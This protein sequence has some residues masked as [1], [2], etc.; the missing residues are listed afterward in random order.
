MNRRDILKHS[1][2]FAGAALS[3]GT[4]SAILSGCQTEAVADLKGSG[5]SQ[6]QL[7][8]ISDIAERI[9]PKTDTPGAK[10]AKVHEFIDKNIALNFTDEEAS[11]FSKGLEMFDNR[12][13]DE[14]GKSFVELTEEEQDK[15]LLYVVD[16]HKGRKIHHIFGQ[17][18][19]EWL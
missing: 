15:V 4:I 6:T 19:K 12:S 7:D 18:L 17:P 10:D 1:T 2:I 9:I 16:H 13:S 3:A 5:L 14:Y 8:L 11:M